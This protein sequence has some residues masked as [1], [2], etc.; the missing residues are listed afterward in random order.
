[1]LLQTATHYWNLRA[2]QTREEHNRT[3]HQQDKRYKKR[4]PFTNK[5]KGQKREKTEHRQTT[6]AVHYVNRRKLH[7]A[8]GKKKG[9]RLDGNGCADVIV[10]A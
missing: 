3:P 6:T 7:V 9:K 10:A 5:K 1:M 2:V 4:M 8:I